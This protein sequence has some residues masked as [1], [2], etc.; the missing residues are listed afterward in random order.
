MILADLSPHLLSPPLW[1]C[2]LW[3]L[4][5]GLLSYGLGR[6]LLP[7][8]YL[9]AMGGL[10]QTSLRAV[11]GLVWISGAM[12][13][14]GLGRVCG[15]ILLPGALSVFA[16]IA[17]RSKGGSLVRQPVPWMALG[18][19][20]VATF[21]LTAIYHDWLTADGRVMP[22]NMDLS[23]FAQMAHGLPEAKAM[24]IWAAALGPFCAE[25]G[26]TGD[27]WYHW[28]PIWLVAGARWL[29]GIPEL[30][31]LFF[32]IAPLLNL[33]LAV[34][35]AAVFQKLTRRSS[36]VSLLVG[37]AS[38]LA[39]SFPSMAEIS[40]IVWLAPDNI[41]PLIHTNLAYQ[42]SYKFEALLIFSALSAWLNGRHSFAALLL[43]L[44]AASAPHTVAG[45]G[46]LLGG[47]GAV[48]VVRRDILALKFSIVCMG[49]LLL[50]WV[51]M[52]VG[53]HTGL[54]KTEGARFMI[55]E[56][57]AISKNTLLALRDI[58]SG[59]LLALPVLPG[60][61]YWTKSSEP[62][63]RRLGWLAVAGLTVPY[64]AYHLLLPEGD[65]AHFIL[66]GHALVV[67]PVGAWGLAAMAK[68]W[69]YALLII[70]CFIGAYDLTLSRSNGS[71]SD[72]MAADLVKVKTELQGQTWGYFAKSD[73]NWWISSQAMLAGLLDT[74]CV[75]LNRIESVDVKSHAAKFYGSHSPE[76]LVPR[77]T[78]EPDNA[79]ALRFARK[80][81]IRHIISTKETPV[82]PEIQSSLRLKLDLPGIKVYELP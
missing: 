67:L 37:A 69:S 76:K 57:G 2:F 61:W 66:Y 35:A 68:K 40:K 58:L 34:K 26:Q 75:R 73:R 60:I 42:F 54:P 82:P 44:A 77:Q 9:G 14:W 46:L 13:V 7:T 16:V 64:F 6:L 4:A 23:Y 28:A 8:R 80:L 31:S 41:N 1:T 62:H 71:P 19:V 33:L 48:S 52:Q 74:R 72:Y 15:L 78:D 32:I 43:F 22:L 21:L 24:N 5:G 10:E 25:A 20:A 47:L 59:L 29:T 51:A 27:I 81:D 11:V 56:L 55:L 17:W 38:I 53:F 65:R 36:A 12:A 70:T 18:V 39:L 63:E 50:G 45:G 3:T 30:M 79:W 49:L